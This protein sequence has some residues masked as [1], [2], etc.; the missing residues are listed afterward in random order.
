MPGTRPRITWTSFTACRS[1]L[2]YLDSSHGANGEGRTPI[3]FREPDPKSGASANSA[4]FARMA[5][6]IRIPRPERSHS[7]YLVCS[8]FFPSASNA[9]TRLR[10][11]CSQAGQKI[12]GAWRSDGRLRS[13]ALLCQSKQQPGCSHIDWKHA[14]LHRSYVH[15]HLR[16]H[17][18]EQS[19]GEAQ[20]ARPDT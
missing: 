6:R 15:A 17:G 16:H 13:T 8:D 2:S 1:I 3:P 20:D 11:R 7:R 14:P 5:F 19:R 18:L 9:S 12:R 10:Y 4:T